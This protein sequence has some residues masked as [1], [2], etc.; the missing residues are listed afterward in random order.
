MSVI[1]LRVSKKLRNEIE[2]ITKTYSITKSEFIRQALVFYLQAMNR[3]GTFDKV[4]ASKIRVRR[5]RDVII[6]SI[7]S[8]LY[9]V[10]GL[11]SA[12]GIGPKP[13]DNVKVDGKVLGRHMTR[14][15]LMD[16]LSVGA[17]PI[18]ITA[19]LGVKREGIGSAIIEGIREE[20]IRIGM[21]P[22]EAIAENT[23]ENFETEQTS[24]GITAL[25]LVKQEDL[26]IGLTMPGDFIVAIGKPLIGEEVI[27]GEV[28]GIIP[29]CNDM[30]KLNRMDFVHDILPVGSFGINHEIL[31]L[32]HAIG[33]GITLN[34][35]VNL[36]LEKSAG[37][38]T[39]I[40]VSL[41]KSGL[42]KLSS[43]ITKPLEVLGEVN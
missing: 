19:N 10:I 18:F 33:R 29:N 28:R 30:I 26:R 13:K 23:E 41:D 36:N 39:V 15:A 4:E 24:V 3:E 8:N 14:V 40:L 16:V 27:L 20:V 43:L 21:N 22:N 11:T 2:S 35:S 12:G 5:W 25:G 31:A 32:S 6:L 7:S 42:K 9:M 37:P 38:A 17:S 34:R 1:N